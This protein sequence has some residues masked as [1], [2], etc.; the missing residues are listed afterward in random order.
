[1]KI[2]HSPMGGMPTGRDR[3]DKLIAIDANKPDGHT[4]R[5]SPAR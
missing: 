5:P 2:G 1:M 4:M 3:A